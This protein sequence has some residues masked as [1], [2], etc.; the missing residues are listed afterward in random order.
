[1]FWLT[2]KAEGTTKDGKDRK[3]WSKGTGD[4][5]TL[6]PSPPLPEIHFHK[7]PEDGWGHV[8][9]HKS[10]IITKDCKTWIT[11]VAVEQTSCYWPSPV[12]LLKPKTI[13]AAVEDIFPR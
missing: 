4:K 8:A 6:P 12:F 7:G 9:K 11:K 1:M 13:S 2:R 5:F 3:P 10:A